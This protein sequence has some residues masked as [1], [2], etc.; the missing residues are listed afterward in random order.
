[1]SFTLRI[2]SRPSALALA[3][4]NLIKDTVVRAGR[5]LAAEVV[6]IST[7]GDKMQTAA[8]A[9]I[10]GKGLFVRELEQGLSARRIDL[11][12]HSMK[13]LPAVLAPQYR[14]AAVPQRES[15]NDALITRSG[16]GWDSLPE[17]VR[18]GTSSTRRRLEAL[19][20]RPDLQVLLLRGN[21][22]TRLQRL[23]AGDFDA[24][25]LAVAGL[26]RLGVIFGGSGPSGHAA[27]VELDGREFV[28]AG[29]QG[30]LAVEALCDGPIAGSAEIEEAIA[31]LN[32]SRTLA[33]VTA[34]R[35]FLAAIGASCVSPVGVNGASKSETL[36]LHAL[37]FSLDG[38]RSLAA[39]LTRDLILGWESASTREQI[40]QITTELGEQLGQQMLDRG[41]GELIGRE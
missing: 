40:E 6:P 17:G 37:L 7:S 31:A 3:Q 13:D 20:L 1:M 8:L 16:G 30:A 33:E 15:P 19:R 34:E 5:G 26:R 27:M 41:A 35:A 39:E 22:D 9:Q 29:G 23:R 36:T 38:T 25:I 11:A 2:G 18:L 12:V 32:D 24:I 14:L 21:V 10:G 4:A 28:P